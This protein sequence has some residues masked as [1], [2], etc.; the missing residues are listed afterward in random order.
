M[1]FSTLVPVILMMIAVD[2]RAAN[3]CGELS[4]SFG[5]FDHAKRNQYVNEF[6][7][8]ESAHFTPE[9]E[10]LVKGS[11]GPVGGDLDYTL[12]A[13]PNH[14]RALASMAR[15]AL[16]DKTTKVGGAKYSVECYFNR[17]IRFTPN[18]ASVRSV[19]GSYL[20]KL[21]RTD[22]A[23]EQLKEAVKLDP[24]NAIANNNLA[25]V[26]MRNKDYE[27]AAV[28][29]RKAESLGFPLTGVKDK[30]KAIGK[31]DVQPNQ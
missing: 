11:T 17:A 19:Y 4:N 12:R 22:E 27:K 1:K 29:A 31:W 14:P 20:F 30:L 24:E 26:Y 9:V 3:Y 23:L 7:L 16:R 10:R 13:I 5:P 15:L 28:L 21:G 6:F 25:L 2:G 18:D 8:V